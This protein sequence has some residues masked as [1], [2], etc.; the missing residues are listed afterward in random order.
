MPCIMKF[1]QSSP[2]LAAPGAGLPALEHFIA[3]LMVH[4]KAW[5]S[6]REKAAIVFA[7]EQDRILAQV[8]L[9]SSEELSTPVLIK[10]LRGLED[11][12]RCWS[13]LMVLDHLRIVNERLSSVISSLCAG[14]VPP[15]KASTADVKPSRDVTEAVITLFRL[16]CDQAIARVSAEPDLKTSLTFAHPWFGQLTAA[17]WHFMLGF[18][19][20]LHRQQIECIIQTLRP[21]KA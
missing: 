6:S 17:Q 21:G 16:G 15:Q 12:S 19:M 7:Q 13:V 8:S 3:N 1:T 4:W 18:H 11:S 20:A 2:P 14:K 10:R 5:R 9:L